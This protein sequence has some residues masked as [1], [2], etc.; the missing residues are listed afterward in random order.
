M[1][2][3]ALLVLVWVILLVRFPAR[4]LPISLL[5]VLALGLVAAWT[6]WRDYQLD[7]RLATIEVSMALAADRCPPGQPLLAVIHNRTDAPLASLR[8]RIG[9][10]APGAATNLVQPG[11]DWPRYAPSSALP[12][13]ERWQSCMA[14]PDLRP[15]FRASTLAFRAERLEGRFD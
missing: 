5:A 3:G 10:Y 7:R 12:P 9:A 14:V 13:G 2:I 8:W 6:A 15:G 1:L 4:A 11:Y